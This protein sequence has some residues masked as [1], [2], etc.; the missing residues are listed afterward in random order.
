MDRDRTDRPLGSARRRTR[1][2]MVVGVLALVA[3]FGVTAA[4][5][6]TDAASAATGVHYV[7]C[8]K[9]SG[10]SGTLRS[11]WSS[12]AQVNADAPF[13]AGEQILL[14]RGTTCVGR[15]LLTGS[16]TAKSPIQVG[17]YGTGAKPLIAGHG[18]PDGTGAVEVDDAAH[19]VIRDLR[20]TNTPVKS[21]RSHRAGVLVINRTKKRLS[22]ITVEDLTVSQVASYPWWGTDSFPHRFGGIA[23]ITSSTVPGAGFDHV[24]IM[25]NDVD[26]VGRSGIVTW[27]AQAQAGQSFDTDL[28][29]SGNTVM[30]AVG[31]GILVAGVKHS[32]ID[33]NVAGYGSNLPKCAL[34]I[35]PDS[36]NTASAGI[37]PIFSQYLRIDHNE[38]YG[39][40]WGPGDGEGFDIDASTS[41]VVF[42]YNYS[43]DN[44]G[45]G[46][47]LCGSTRV[48]VRFNI[49]ENNEK[50]A[51]A[52]IGT[53]P[54]KN[55]SIYNNTI[56]QAKKSDAGVVR[57]FNGPAGS[58]L[59]FYNNIVFSYAKGYYMWPTKVVSKRNTY[60]GTHNRNEP[61]GKGYSWSNPLLKAPGTGGNGRSTLGGYKPKHPATFPR[62]VAVPPS[63]KTDFFGKK[64]DPK[65]PTRGAAA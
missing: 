22:G 18:T 6:G 30:H 20:I 27:N 32:R 64:I 50:S 34:S 9:K 55:T 3:S 54:A 49:F 40:K 65:H 19:W 37:W 26:H 11:P 47:L 28:R 15:L 23:V 10:G 42:E 2:V 63:V 45:G 39:T 57:Y 41:D 1:A 13:R 21:D 38:A 5:S 48:I 53:M 46:L 31:D 4:S 56:Y 36:K 33:H 60:V 12:L 62:G 25:S 58:G 29:V 52:F 44:E 7:D 35:C 61:H 14:K 43:H 8:A 59:K 24:R 16:G 17:S 51:L